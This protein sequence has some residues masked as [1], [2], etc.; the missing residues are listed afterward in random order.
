MLCTAEAGE[1]RRR[2]HREEDCPVPEGDLSMA[3]V[4]E[5]SMSIAAERKIA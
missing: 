3:V 1:Q 2:E 5:G 4:T